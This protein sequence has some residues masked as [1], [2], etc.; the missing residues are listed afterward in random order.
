MTERCSHP[1][2]GAVA[3]IG[4]LRRDGGWDRFCRDHKADGERAFEARRAELPLPLPPTRGLPT[5]GRR[6]M[7]S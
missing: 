1:G 4:F 2:C 5:G 7:T 3:F 6:R